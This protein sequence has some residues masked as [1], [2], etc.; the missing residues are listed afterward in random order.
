[1]ARNVFI[2]YSSKD[3]DAAEAICRA[4]EARGIRCWMA[5]RDI[6]PG[7]PWAES[8]LDALENASAMLL[9]FTASANASVQIHREI[10]RAVHKGVP[11]IPLRLENVL[12]TRT[13]EYFISTTHWLDVHQPPLDQHMDRVAQAIAALLGKPEALA[14]G[15]AP[16]R[17]KTTKRAFPASLPSVALPPTAS[18]PAEAPP[19]PAAASV[20]ARP[21]SL[22]N[23][24]LAQLLGTGRF[25]SMVY[26]GMHRL[27][28]YPVAIRTFRAGPA[29]NRNA[30]RERFLREGLSLQVI[31]PNVIHVKDFG[32]TGEVMYVVT[33]LLP[34]CSL[35][36]LM[37]SE[38]QL[39]FAKLVAFVQELTDATEAV[40]AHGGLISGLHPEIVRVVR[41]HGTER[42]AISSAGISTARDLLLVMNE[43][44]LRGQAT[45]SELCYVAPELLMGRTADAGSDVFT[46]GALAY[47]MATGR[48]PFEGASLPELLGAMLGAPPPDVAEARPDIRAVA[49]AT[50][51]RCIASDPR[52]R[53]GTAAE[54][55]RAWKAATSA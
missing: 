32:E 55:A 26:A 16:R 15:R 25:G 42:L 46:I 39:P 4:L 17:R 35:G 10:D 12:P 14:A 49:A 53:F 7:K 38:R 30:V 24:D 22:G 54:V 1:M 40:H 8:I 51:T 45:A 5:P 36:K 11:V 41:E 9:L 3:H 29:D 34:G 44:T 13:M 27:L 18:P 48:P 52:Q 20:D 6:L 33:D 21:M 28:G 31:H 23:Y 19:P 47:L 43:A 37:S 2:S 50:I